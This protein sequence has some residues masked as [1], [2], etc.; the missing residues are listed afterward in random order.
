VTSDDTLPVT[1][2]RSKTNQ[3]CPR[4]L[5]FTPAEPEVAAADPDTAAAEE[6]AAAADNERRAAAATAALALVDSQEPPQPQAAAA[7]MSD[8]AEEFGATALEALQVCSRTCD[9]PCSIFGPPCSFLRCLACHSSGVYGVQ[10]LSIV[11]G[12][13]NR[14]CTCRRARHKRLAVWKRTR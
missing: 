14:R 10:T 8:L 2:C 4:P 6:D 3:V 12:G 5:V 9:I 13:V 11:E 7:A 1:V